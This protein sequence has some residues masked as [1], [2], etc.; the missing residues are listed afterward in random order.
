ME[1]DYGIVP[2]VGGFY[3]CGMDGSVSEILE[4]KE[5]DGLWLVRMQEIESTHS[6]W[7]DANFWLNTDT[8]SYHPASSRH[9][10][11]QWA[12]IYPSLAE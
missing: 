7:Q 11:P 8:W 1:E 10:L 6:H 9:I 3:T 2:E 4:V 5:V 12:D